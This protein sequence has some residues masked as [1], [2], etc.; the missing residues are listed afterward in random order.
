MQNT[1]KI[2]RLFYL[3]FP[4]GALAMLNRLSIRV[5]LAILAVMASLAL[6]ALGGIN[7][8]QT[9]QLTHA[10]EQATLGQGKIRNQGEADMMHDAIRGDVLEMYYQA[11]QADATPAA[12]QEVRQSLNEHS[13]TLRERV[14]STA[15]LPMSALERKEL[16]ALRPDLDAYVREAEHTL[17]ILARKGDA[18]AAFAAF[19]QRFDALEKSMGAFSST[20]E[21]TSQVEQ[22][23]ARDVAE[24]TGQSLL[25]ALLACMETR[26]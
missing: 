16:D 8:W 15:S 4:S 2:K 12:L 11:N 20:L 9:Q 13:K 18:K 19:S 25:L 10:L 17:D 21:R 5:R 6:V 24:H 23:A 14:A 26:V 7:Y 1:K 22:D 3:F